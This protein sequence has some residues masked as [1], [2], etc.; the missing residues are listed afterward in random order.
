VREKV[1]DADQAD[2]RD[3]AKFKKAASYM[4]FDGRQSVLQALP[5][6]FDVSGIK[7]TAFLSE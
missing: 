2:E 7:T 5:R 6:P 4:V 1:I 3:R